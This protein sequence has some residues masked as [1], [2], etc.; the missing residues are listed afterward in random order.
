MINEEFLNSDEG[1]VI[2]TEEMRREYTIL[3]P[4]LLPRHFKLLTKVFA[5]FG[6]KVEQLENGLDGDSREIIDAGLKNVH[7]D[8]CYPA[9]IMIGQCIHALNS[10]RYDTHKVAIM[11]TQTGGGCRASNY[12]SLIRK[13]LKKAG[14][15]YIPVVSLNLSGIEKN[16]GFKLTPK[17]ISP[18]LNS[19]LFGDLLMCLYNQARAR[20]KVK[21]S[22]LALADEWTD[23]LAEEMTGKMLPYSRVKQYYKEIIADFAKID[24]KEEKPI[25]V[26]IVGEIF[27]KFS[28]LGNNSLEDFLVSEGAEPVMAGLVDFILYCMYNPIIDAKLYGRG[29]ASVPIYIT[30]CEYIAKK[31]QDMIDAIAE[32]G[33]FTPPT[34]FYKTCHA[35]EGYIGSGM[36]MGEGWLLTAEM[37]DLIESGVTNIVC[38]QP[39]GC[40]PNHIAGKGMMKP[41]KERNPGVNIVAIDYDSGATKINQEN[42]I[43][44]MLASAGREL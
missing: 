42:R 39:F 11:M 3:L 38:A 6:Y 9:L 19:M 13:A 17:M 2:F 28:P 36:K 27:V 23:R 24:S 10:G 4:N 35:N 37:L 44:L 8:V 29:R 25:K 18:T 20:E 22:A 1:R 43:K 16:P 41:I 30:V 32:E 21:G 14:Y 40:L 15:G 31:Q 26:G 34:P 12:V 5:Q 33:S 7:N